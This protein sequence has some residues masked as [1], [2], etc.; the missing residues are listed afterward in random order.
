M[1]PLVTYG[2]AEAST[3]RKPSIPCTFM[4]V[5][6]TTD[7]STAPILQVHEGCSAV[8]PSFATQSRICS[9]VST[10]GPGDADR[11]NPFPA[12]LRGRKVVEPEL[13]V[14]SRVGGL[15][16]HRASGVGVHGADVDLVAVAARRDGA[17]VAD[18]NRQEV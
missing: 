5:G 15:D 3:T 8:S 11:L 2:I 13:R 7:P 12:V 18:R 14:D 1:L 17:V 6:S 10:L 16:F 9:P 4:L